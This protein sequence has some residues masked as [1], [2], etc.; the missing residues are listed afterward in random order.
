MEISAKVRN[1]SATHEVTV[2]TAGVV[3]SLDIPAKTEGSGSAVNGGEFLMLA[4]ATCYCNDL[5]REAKRMNIAIDGVEVEA[6]ACF[7]GVGLAANNIQYR[8]TVQSLACAFD[9]ERLI[10]ET[11]AVAEVHNTLR[12]GVQVLLNRQN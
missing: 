1:S 5:Y 8:A 10:S 3:R 11:D 12:T 4:L 9:I 6:S 2:S 7:E